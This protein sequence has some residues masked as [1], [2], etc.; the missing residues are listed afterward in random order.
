VPGVIVDEA[1]AWDVEFE[2]A[3]C[4]LEGLIVRFFSVGGEGKGR[5]VGT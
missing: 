1:E 3:R 2:G 4:F 5:E